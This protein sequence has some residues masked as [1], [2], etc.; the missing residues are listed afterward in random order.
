VSGETVAYTY[1]SLQR[2]VHAETTAG[3]QW[4]QSYNYDGFGNF[5]WAAD[6]ATNRTGGS[7]ANGNAWSDYYNYDVEN[8]NV[9][10]WSSYPTSVWLRWYDSAGKRVIEK[11][12]NAEGD[13]WKV[14]L[15][16]VTGQ[17]LA[18]LCTGPWTLY[19]DAG[20]NKA[21]I[22]F[23]GKMIVAGGQSVLTD[24]LGSVRVYGWD[25]TS[26]YP[27]GQEKP[28]SQT[29]NERQKFGGY[30]R[31][32]QFHD[33]ADQRYYGTGGRFESPDPL[34]LAG[35][36]LK[37]P[38]SWNRYVY[39]VDDPVNFNDPT[40]LMMC[41]GAGFEGVDG[42]GSGCGYPEWWCEYPG[43]PMCFTDPGGGMGGSFGNRPANPFQ[44]GGWVYDVITDNCQTGSFGG[45]FGISCPGGN[46]L[47][48]TPTTTTLGQLFRWATT[49]VG[50]SLGAV[51]AGLLNP[52]ATSGT[53]T[54]YYNPDFVEAHCTPVGPPVIVPST[55]YPGG[56]S[57]EQEYICADGNHYT[58]H[59]LKTKTG[60]VKDR[61]VRQ[62]PPKYGD[63]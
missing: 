14:H 51:I 44:P 54:L 27:Y 47:A 8:R 36:D 7:D 57:N 52:S 62:G 10:D 17:R 41:E 43:D 24:R 42:K 40:G 22:Y 4:S 23:A 38:I 50:T 1:D 5:L 53:D 49:V 9:G 31:D 35:V 18:T 34:G 12:P 56:T 61:H 48:P 37:N 59:T 28:S 39:A 33:Y 16:S 21:N 2:L 45:V 25:Q 3:P 58:V 60:I 29:P 55:K 26:Y 63:E 32:N 6:P 30:F 20:C 19:T 13:W 15:Y 46:L 11:V